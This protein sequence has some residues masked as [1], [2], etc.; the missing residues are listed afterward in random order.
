M[1]RMWEGKGLA[2]YAKESSAAGFRGGSGLSKRRAAT[3]ARKRDPSSPNQLDRLP[4]AGVPLCGARS[5]R[6][7]NDKYVNCKRCLTLL[8]QMRLLEPADD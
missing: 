3:H 5:R 1:A 2:R 7:H 8:A 4:S 6:T